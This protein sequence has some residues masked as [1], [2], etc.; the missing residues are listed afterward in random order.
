MIIANGAGADMHSDFINYFHEELARAGYLTVKFNFL[1]QEQG[2]K[3][4]D[5][6][7][8]LEKTYL[9]IYN[10]LVEK[11]KIPGKNVILGGKSMG[12]RIATQIADRTEAT[13]IVLYGYPLHPPGKTEKLR[14]AHLY[15]LKAR[16]LFIQGTRDKLCDPALL[17][18]VLKKIPDARLHSIDQGDHSFA[19]PKRSG[20]DQQAVFTEVVREVMRFAGR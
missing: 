19:V 16:L 10:Y 12:G 5:A 3:S 2:R 9:A 7:G 15:K 17:Q 14:D 8:K 13:R 20:I 18:K 1:Y 11:E 6:A 4:P